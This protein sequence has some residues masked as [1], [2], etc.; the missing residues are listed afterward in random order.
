MQSERPQRAFTELVLWPKPARTTQKLRPRTDR[1]EHVLWP[2]LIH[3]LSYNAINLNPAVS[4]NKAQWTDSA[5]SAYQASVRGSGALARGSETG[6]A[7]E[8]NNSTR[9]RVCISASVLQLTHNMV[10]QFIKD[11][12]THSFALQF[13]FLNKKSQIQMTAT[14]KTHKKGRRLRTF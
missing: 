14:V 8:Q 11:H 10:A 1:T 2:S 4:V 12:E 13:C 5:A 3:T 7:G 9:R 6:N